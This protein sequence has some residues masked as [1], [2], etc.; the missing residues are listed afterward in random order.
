VGDVTHTAGRGAV[1]SA[2]LV[3]AGRTSDLPRV[4]EVHLRAF[5]GFFLSKLGY[6]FLTQYYRVALG[7]E[8]ALFFV[9][10]D[11]SGKCVGFAVG[12]ANPGLFYKKL[13]KSWPLFVVPILLA[14]IRTPTLCL[15]IIKRVFKVERSST[16]SDALVGE[17]ASIGVA[18]AGGGTGTKLVQ[19]FL[20]KAKEDG[21]SEIR[22]STDRD[23]NDLANAF[24]I[25]HGFLLIDVDKNTARPMNI[26]SY[27]LTEG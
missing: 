12:F 13:I 5:A 22:L 11:H 27:N 24:Y 2:C 10:E 16:L 26:Y 18:H 1:L 15:L 21:V 8:G 19:Y 23:N 25:K 20:E 4:A 17:L 7:V 3:R 9:A 6:G 14:I